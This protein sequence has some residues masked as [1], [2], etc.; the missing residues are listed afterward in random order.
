MLNFAAGTGEAKA[1]GGHGNLQKMGVGKSSSGGGRDV[2]LGDLKAGGT[3][4]AGAG[5][6]AAENDDV[7]VVVEWSEPG[8]GLGAAAV[9]AEDQ[10]G[11][12]HV[13][14]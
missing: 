8:D 6:A 9:D 14:D 10:W 5:K 1:G 13:K 4:V 11:R 7:R 12:G 3:R 2:L